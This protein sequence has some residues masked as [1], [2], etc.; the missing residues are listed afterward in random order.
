MLDK[1]SNSGVTKKI[2]ENSA[3]IHDKII[4]ARDIQKFEKGT[5]SRKGKF[6][7]LEAAKWSTTL[8]SCS[9]VIL[10]LFPNL[11]LNFLSRTAF[12]FLVFSSDTR[13]GPKAADCI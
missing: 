4:I 1:F 6:I 7:T 10:F 13:I 9:L 8:N 2:P 12:P 11:N 3:Y 5:I